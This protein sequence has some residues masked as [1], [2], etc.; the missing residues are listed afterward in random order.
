MAKRLHGIFIVKFTKRFSKNPS[1]YD[2]FMY[3]FFLLKGHAV[4]Y[5]SNC[6]QSCFVKFISLKWQCYVYNYISFSC[7][8]ILYLSLSSMARAFSR[9]TASLSLSASSNPSCSACVGFLSPSDSDRWK[10]QHVR[11][12]QAII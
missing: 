7:E 3:I 1:I 8:T 10:K 6:P 2:R 9:R 4:S 11:S 5:L 12:H